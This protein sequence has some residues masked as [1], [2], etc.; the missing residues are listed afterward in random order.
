MTYNTGDYVEDILAPGYFRKIL[1]VTGD[2]HFT[3][4]VWR[5]GEY[6]NDPH[7]LKNEDIQQGIFTLKSMEQLFNPTTSERA[8]NS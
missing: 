6:S 2:I 7:G 3:S 4:R 8:K 1:H 5:E